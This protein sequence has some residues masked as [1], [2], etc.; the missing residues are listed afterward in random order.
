M[1]GKAPS[2]VWAWGYN[3]FG[4]LGNGTNGPN[5][6]SPVPAR[7]HLNDVTAIAAG[8]HHVLAVGPTGAVWGWGDNLHGELGDGMV[9]GFAP[10]PQRVPNV[11]AVAVAAGERHSLALKSDGTVR[12]WGE[13]LSGQLGIGSTAPISS[14]PVQVV[15]L[16]DIVAV[17]AGYSHSLAV[18]SDGTLWTWGENGD[19]QLGNGSIADSP[20]PVQATGLI[21]VGTCAGGEYHSLAL[22]RNGTVWAWGTNFFGQL[23]DGTYNDSRTPIEIPGLTDVIAVAA[24][25]WNSLALRADGTV[26]AWGHDPGIGGYSSN[27]PV[28]PTGLS[29]I[30]AIAGGNGRHLL[31][32]GADGNLWAWG[33]NDYGQLGDGTKNDRGAPVRVVRVSPVATM[34]GGLFHSAAVVGGGTG[35]PWAWGYNFHGQLG[36][37]TTN[38]SHVPV[39][40]SIVTGGVA[41]SAGEYHSTA[42]REDGGVWAWGHNGSGQLGDGTKTDS[43]VPIEV[44]GLSDVTAIAALQHHTLA[45]KADGT[46]WAWGFNGASEL[47][48]GTATDRA[49][50]VEVS[51]ITDAVAISGGVDHSL[52]LLSNGLVVAW[53]GNVFGQ[54]GNPSAGFGSLTPVVVANLSDVVGIAGG[55]WHNVA[56][57]SDGTIWA[58]GMND[59]RQVARASPYSVSSPVKVAGISA[60]VVAVGAG[61]WHGLALK[62][63][64]TVWQWGYDGVGQLVTGF[65]TAGQQVPWQV[66]GV[67]DAIAVDGGMYH[68]AALRADGTVWA[69]GG[70][71]SGPLGDGTTTSSASAVRSGPLDRVV[72]VSAGGG[73]TL[74]LRRTKG[75]RLVPPKLDFG[76][77]ALGRRVKETLTLENDGTDA[78]TL[79]DVTFIAD[80]GF[81]LAE[82]DCK[83]PTKLEPGAGCRMTIVFRPDRLGPFS[84]LLRI[85][86]DSPRTYEVAVTALGV[87]PGEEG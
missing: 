72:A 71:G 32:L 33:D 20:L 63:D 44:L 56:L 25:R 48:D 40:A 82:S 30:V 12:A 34:A 4:Q 37:G 7:A 31:A 10:E 18:M 41:V 39:Q 27:V 79:E 53:G 75:L 74:A 46:V 59:V 47:G 69:W 38:E 5:A 86:D 81:K 42:L 28:Q 3:F 8:K 17:G 77:V 52:A 21:D 29:D 60:T 68:S 14:T 83:P 1:S 35:D 61:Y 24:A 6:E 43:H 36:D 13:N 65:P 55:G 9:S 26:W 49:T 84:A 57:K 87:Q 51:G 85:T 19:G 2:S 76:R 66:A 67:S 80:R 11:V 73:V 15:G 54:L 22:K 45:L 64:G 78:V 62:T 50:P 16:V 70:N 58:W 23:G